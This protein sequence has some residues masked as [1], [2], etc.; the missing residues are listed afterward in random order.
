MTGLG[1]LLTRNFAHLRI[2]NLPER[3][4]R[5]QETKI[6]FSRLSVPMDNTRVAFFA[7]NRPDDADGF[8]SA[9]AR[10]CFES[11]LAVIERAIVENVETLLVMEDDICFVPQIPST[12]EAMTARLACDDWSIFYGGFYGASPTSIEGDAGLTV[13]PHDEKLLTTHCIGFRR[14]ALL[15]IA[16]YLRQM[17]ER[18]AGSVDGGPMHVD[19]A[20]NWFRRAHPH[21]VTIAAIPPIAG[22]RPSR[23]D[24]ALPGFL[25]R[26]IFLRYVMEYLR[27]LK[28][29]SRSAS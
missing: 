4:D 24:I 26:N 8:P 15:L 16:P 27:R 19:G 11:H 23:S 17:L 22:Q 21:L 13:V 29:M 28:R 18:T 25:D 2:I 9:G 5:R 1:Q 3:A 6:E 7:A 20:Y 10:G 12:V 14:D